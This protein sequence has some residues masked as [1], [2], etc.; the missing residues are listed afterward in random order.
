MKSLL[1]MALVAF[2]SGAQAQ[3]KCT[4][5]GKPIYSDEPCA[6][7]AQHVGKPYDR[8]T[9]DQQIQRLQQSIKERK[10]R[11]R[12]ER[13]E[14]IEDAAREEVALARRAEAQ[15]KA[16]IAA[17][18][19][20]RRCEQLQRDLK[21]NERSAARYQDFGWQRSLTQQE[22]EAKRNREAMDR[23]CR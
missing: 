18:D 20:K 6:R 9:K 21:W 16:E 7:D 11:N 4:V 3:Y 13:R 1:F 17:A 15:R 10:E 22:I 5:N 23:E 12:I 2:A 14:A 19:R 8:V